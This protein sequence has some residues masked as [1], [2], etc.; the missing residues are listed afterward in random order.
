MK[1]IDLQSPEQPKKYIEGIEW[2][3]VTQDYIRQYKNILSSEECKL[4]V[5][6]HDDA[7]D[8]WG[9]DAWKQTVFNNTRVCDITSIAD[10]KIDNIL[11]NAFGRMLKLYAEDFWRAASYTTDT[12][13][14]LTRYCKGD[15]YPMHHEP[16]GSGIVATISLSSCEGGETQFFGKEKVDSS[17]G[18]GFIYPASFLFP[19][20]VLPVTEG[21]RFYVSTTFK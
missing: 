5:D 21:L 13:Y 15:C 14:S 2:D 9:D 19:S 18:T 12:G 11:F 16:S 17:I 6:H 4:I 20:E 3:R 1:V 8:D 7:D 10:S